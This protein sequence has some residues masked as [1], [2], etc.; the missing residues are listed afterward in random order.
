MREDLTG[1][2]HENPLI[3]ST[4]IQNAFRGKLARKQLKNKKN[5]KND[6][7]IEQSIKSNAALNLRRV[8]Q[9]HRARKQIADE[10]KVLENQ[11]K[12]VEKTVKKAKKEHTLNV[13]DNLAYKTRVKEGKYKAMDKLTKD[14]LNVSESITTRGQTEK[15]A[16][17]INQDE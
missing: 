6:R 4:A 1:T 2:P 16:K 12:G 9:G 10:A 11:I 8:F 13:L 3:A 17:K 14:I 15:K 5:E 7:N